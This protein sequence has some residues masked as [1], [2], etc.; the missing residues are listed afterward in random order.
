[1]TLNGNFQFHRADLPTALESERVPCTAT[2]DARSRAADILNFQRRMYGGGQNSLPSAQ[3]WDGLAALW[4][5]SQVCDKGRP[6]HELAR[7]RILQAIW[8]HPAIEW[9][10]L[11]SAVPTPGA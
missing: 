9:S 11:R 4:R 6:G 7:G 1:M 3:S 5:W 10:I 2:A 8:S